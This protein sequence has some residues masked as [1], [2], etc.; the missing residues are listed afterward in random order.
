MSG[1]MVSGETNDIFYNGTA[2]TQI[3]PGDMVYAASSAALPAASLA[4]ASNIAGTQEAFHDAFLGVSK[5]Q[6]VT[7]DT[8]T[9]K[10]C[11]ATT[12]RYLVSCK[13]EVAK[14]IG[15]LYGVGDAG[16]NTIYSQSVQSVATANLAV[17]RLSKA[18]AANATEVE[19]EIVSTGTLGGPQTAI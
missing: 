5:D 11:I 14:D 13:D 10:I 8:G 4:W 18:K 1:R 6:K 16:G 3:N 9:T 2:S 19:L 7:A 17:G 15:Q 12:G